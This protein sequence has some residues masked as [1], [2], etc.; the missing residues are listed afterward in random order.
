MTDRAEP[1][2]SSTTPRVPIADLTM[3]DK[4]FQS[5]DQTKLAIAL[6]RL[7][8]YAQR[9]DIHAFSN[10]VRSYQERYGHDIADEAM[11]LTLARF[12]SFAKRAF[13]SLPEELLEQ[14]NDQS[15]DAIAEVVE[16]AGLLLENHFR[17]G[18]EGIALSRQAVKAIAETGYPL[19][20]E[21]GEG[22]DSLEGVGLKRKGGFVHPLS[23]NLDD[24]HINSWAAVSVTISGAMGWLDADQGKCSDFLKELVSRAAPTIDLPRLMRRS[25][26]DDRALLKLYNTANRGFEILAHAS[27]NK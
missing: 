6:R 2:A 13:E 26:Y 4:D 27:S 11:R 9:G 14:I 5:S 17:V 12:P 10:E 18:D 22:N 3:S 7:A 8:P 23:E 24:D 19:V 16:S 21:F 25:R 1:L 15:G 20:L